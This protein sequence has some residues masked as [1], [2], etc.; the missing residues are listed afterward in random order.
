M[1]SPGL[2]CHLSRLYEISEVKV[3]LSVRRINDG[4]DSG[5]SSVVLNRSSSQVLPKESINM[6][7]LCQVARRQVAAKPS[8][9]ACLP[10]CKVPEMFLREN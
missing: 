9:V 5:H 6:V 2:S 7:H 3:S 1:D 10:S 4:K 8:Q